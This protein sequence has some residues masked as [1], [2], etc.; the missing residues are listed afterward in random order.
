MDRKRILLII[1]F[2]ISVGVFGW[3]LYYF[4]FRALPGTVPTNGVNGNGT[5]PIPTN[6]N[7][8]VI[9]NQSRNVNLP[10][11]G[12]NIDIT[13]PTDI[14]RGGL[15][16]VQ[17]I[18]TN[19]VEN[20]VSN[21]SGTVFY[22]PSTA[23]FYRLADGKQTV[24]SDR[25][26]T[27][28][29]KA[30]WSKDQSKAILEFPDGSNV[31]YNF[32]TNTQITLPKEMTEFSFDGSGGSIAV[33]WIGDTKEDNWLMVGDADGSNFRLIEPLGDQSTNV[34][35][36]YS[37]DSQVVAVVRR[38]IDADR[39]EVLPIG[40]LGQNFKSFTIEG[41]KFESAWAPAGNTLL[42]NISTAANNYNP[43]LWL[44]SGSTATLGSSHLDLKLHTW[45]SKCTFDATGN[46]VYCAEPTS[47]P[48]GT[49]LYPELADGIPDAFFR[50][51]L[52]TGQKIPLALPVGSQL[53]YSAK[54]VQLSPDE[55]QLYFVDSVTN[56]VHSIR[57]K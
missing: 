52:R 23:Q 26:F 34:Q 37:P 50:I 11:F 10:S 19:P 47:L 39:Q 7:I 9:G 53:L 28:V 41:L 2:I 13:A 57:L 33:K 56:Q 43:E 46:S 44:T 24:L 15:T 6:G 55:S 8:G 45:A 32:K 38:P 20:F 21:G 12:N 36:G 31:V 17:D 5:L 18:I 35:V 40:A 4:F 51:D 3:L 29:E 54:S 48:T 25:K 16:K 14:A 27:G 49:G 30:T 42:Y 22:N 1:G